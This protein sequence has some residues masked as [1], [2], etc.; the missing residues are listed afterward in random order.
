[1]RNRTPRIGELVG[2]LDSEFS[3]ES[4]SCESSGPGTF[5]TQMF[6]L[7]VLPKI[8]SDEKK[9]NVSHTLYDEVRSRTTDPSLVEF[10]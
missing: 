5:H 7:D 4:E 1:M 8:S 2:D 10:P 6:G 3:A 9:G